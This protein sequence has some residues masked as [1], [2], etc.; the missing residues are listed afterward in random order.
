MPAIEEMSLAEQRELHDQCTVFLAGHGPATAAGL[1][2]GI[3]A[4]TV[5][6]RYGSGGV[7]ADLETEVGGLL[8]KGHLLDGRHASL[9]AVGGL[10]SGPPSAAA[11]PERRMPCRSYG[12]AWGTRPG[13]GCVMP[14]TG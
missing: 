4:D 1:L 10:R 7:V 5:T 3:P 12:R 6:D 14:A 8:G 2:A 11:T 13:H 9:C